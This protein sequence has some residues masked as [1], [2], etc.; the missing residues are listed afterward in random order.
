MFDGAGWFVGGAIV[1]FAVAILGLLLGLQ[2]PD[3]VLW[4]GQQVVGT[5]QGGIVLYHWHGE[6][7]SFAVPGFGSSKAVSVYFD[8]SDPSQAMT[9]SVT[10]RVLAALFTLGPVTGAVV[11]L[12]AGGTRRYR[13]ERE[14]FKRAREF[15]L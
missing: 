13:W 11:L 6:S 4:T 7:Y 5:E 10:D 3:H 15:T 8:P 2:A 1:L 14:K 9:D 12:V